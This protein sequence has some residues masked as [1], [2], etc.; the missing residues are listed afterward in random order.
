MKGCLYVLIRGR[1]V[2]ALSLESNIPRETF[3]GGN[4]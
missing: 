4:C 1:V 3:G 2:K